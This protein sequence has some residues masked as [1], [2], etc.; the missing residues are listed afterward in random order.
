MAAR[1]PAIPAARSASGRS[2]APSAPLSR[3]SRRAADVLL[4]LTFP[5]L[6]GLLYGYVRGGRLRNLGRFEICHWWLLSLA[7]LAQVVRYR[8]VPGF[9]WLL[10]T[11]PSLRP[12]LIIFA[13]VAVW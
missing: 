5:A 2:A 10:G 9:H 13:L 1:Q 4:L 7:A 8:H 3:A 12:T 11:Y 6:L